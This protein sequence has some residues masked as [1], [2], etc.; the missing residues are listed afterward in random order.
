MLTFLCVWIESSGTG[1]G[2]SR[3][4]TVARLASEMLDKLPPAYIPHVIVERLGA[5]GK[6]EPMVIF[7]G[8]EIDRM[9]KVCCA[10]VY[11]LQHIL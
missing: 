3:E 1:G 2:E 10:L 6:L 7:L 8:Q 4:A 5:L 9:Q 11:R